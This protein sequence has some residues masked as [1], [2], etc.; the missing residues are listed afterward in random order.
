ML[1]FLLIL[2]LIPFAIVGICWAV[3]L[4]FAL[5]HGM[6]GWMFERRRY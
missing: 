4:A 2:A 5:L 3:I 1:E 6:F